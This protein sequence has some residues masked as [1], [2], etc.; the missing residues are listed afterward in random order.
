[1]LKYYQDNAIRDS[2]RGKEWVTLLMD[3]PDA[4]MDINN[5]QETYSW[6]TS[7]P[8]GF[9]TI[10]VLHNIGMIHRLKAWGKANFVELSPGYVNTVEEFFRGSSH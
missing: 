8:E 5:V 2:D 4:G 3:E 7:L 1:M 6:L 10:I 9:Q